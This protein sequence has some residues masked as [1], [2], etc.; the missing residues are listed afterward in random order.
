VCALLGRE[1]LV[2]A[3]AGHPPALLASRN[4]EVRESPTPGP[5]LGAFE[6]AKFRQDEVPIAAGDVALVY[7]DGVLQALGS[8]PVGRDRL[9]A[10]LAEQAGQPPQAV[11]SRLETA[12]H[13][14]RHDARADDLA[15]LA[16][17]RR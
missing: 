2:L 4:R 16:L 6:D 17:A 14:Y 10:L 9:R 1:R 3:S 12:L 7:T 15:A 13:E 5:L 8:G 11:L